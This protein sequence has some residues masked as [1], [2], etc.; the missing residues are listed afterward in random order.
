MQER[1]RS[2]TPLSNPPNAPVGRITHQALSAE[3]PS[4]RAEVRQGTSRVE[5]WARAAR[6]RG[7]GPLLRCG[8]GGTRRAPPR[9]PGV[10]RHSLLGFF[11]PQERSQASLPMHRSKLAC[12]AA[13]W[14]L[15]QRVS[16]ITLGAL[17]AR[18][19]HGSRHER[20]EQGVAGLKHLLSLRRETGLV[21]QQ[22]AGV[23][24][25]PAQSPWN[26]FHAA[27]RPR[28]FCARFLYGKPTPRRSGP[29]LVK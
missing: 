16:R 10:R 3:S 5:L 21:P 7:H 4:P 14:Q 13:T 22:P 17:C 25:S 9:R 15:K 29:E 26:T 1:A 11:A 2:R 8:G 28:F 12:E 18:Y 23:H 20:C 27:P 24:G 19:C 6:H